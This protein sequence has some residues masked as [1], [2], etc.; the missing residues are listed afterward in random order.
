MT[1]VLA[2]VLIPYARFLE[3]R[4]RRLDI[5]TELAQ[6]NG[7]RPTNPTISS[8][9]IANNERVKA[10]DRILFGKYAGQEIKIDGREYFIMKEDDV[11]AVEEGIVPG[12]GVVGVARGHRGTPRTAESR[13]MRARC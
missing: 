11:L 12:G 4:A 9:P 10:G 7:Q 8:G 3:V 13:D 5:V 6:S 2:P 1:D